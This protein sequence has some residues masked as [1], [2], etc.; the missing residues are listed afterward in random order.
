MLTPGVLPAVSDARD[1]KV[2][3]IDGYSGP[4]AGYAENALDG[5]KLAVSEINKKKVL[6][7]KIVFVTRDTKLDADHAV[8]MAKQLVESEKVD[9]L[10]GT[11]NSR[12]AI[13]VSEAVAKKRKVP[14]IVWISKSER[15]TGEKGHRYVFSTGEN[16]AMAGKAI[17]LELSGKPY[18]KYWIAGDDNEYG[19]TM[20]DA[21]WRNLRKMKPEVSVAG[22]SW[23]KPN[24]ADLVPHITQ[25][26][27]G[28]PHAV[29]FCT[30]ALNI[31]KFLKAIKATDMP[32]KVPVWIHI[33]TAH[34]VLKSLWDDAPEGVM[35]TADYHFYHPDTKANKEFSFAFLT[36][37]GHAPGSPAY[38]GYNTAR[39]IAGAYRKAGGLHREKF[40]DAL[41]G[42]EISSP[43]GP[44]EMRACDHQAVL[45]IFFGITKKSARYESAISSGIVTLRGKAVMPTCDEIAAARMK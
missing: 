38:H 33:A 4:L 37:F 19:H 27:E 41:E 42:L 29:V 7:E 31:A 10:V 44:I 9:L 8:K 3:I 12:S 21:V 15:I 28:Q 16:T 20:A 24:E 34:M 18:I 26:L 11:T 22:T 2:G 36:A 32:G 17:S 6:G 5:F 30:G 39:F 40:I 43:M 35:G 13:A 1:I 23:W 45:P 14:F 25:I